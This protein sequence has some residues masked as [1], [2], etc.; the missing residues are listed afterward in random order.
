MVKIA[1]KSAVWRTM[2]LPN[3]RNYMIGNLFSQFGMWVQRIAVAWL[4]W[5]LTQSPTWLGIIAM[6]D[7]FPNVIMAPLAGA[8]AD[9]MDRLKAIRVYVSV[10]AIISA[11]IAWLTIG[12]QITV[13]TLLILVLANGIVM[14]FNYPVRLSLIQSLVGR[15]ALTS[16]VSVNAIFF[17]V[18]RI[19]GPAMAGPAI[20]VWG[21]GP[22]LI[23]TVIADIIFV[24]VLYKVHLLDA[25]TKTKPKPAR[26]LPAEIK[27][28]FRYAAKHPGIGPLLIILVTMAIFGRSF[29]ELLP[30]FADNIFGRG[31]DGFA[32]FTVMM[33]LGSFI[34][35]I[36]LAKREG[37]TGLTNILINNTLLL[38]V[39]AI[40]FAA[41]NIFWVGLGFMII[42]GYAI[43]AIGVTEQTLIQMAVDDSMR[44]RML[45]FYTLI[46]RGCPSIGALLMGSL[47]SI[48]GLQLPIIFGAV[49]C[50]GVWAWSRRKRDLL[51]NSL[52]G[53]LQKI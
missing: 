7:F 23:F 19:G 12:G 18:A 38:S 51:V 44:G 26:H 35:S 21:V 34:G 30:G 47:S 11:I 28:G 17:N 5:E 24:A 46:A 39:S 22:V 36:V 29:I 14:S 33:G 50:I 15:D 53:E 25:G 13:E 48:F 40:G 1:G 3:Y 8:L 37:V 32:L 2:H 6:A 42:V 49:I 41:T 45:S 31:V 10:S 9:R 52:E 4:T 16:A 20:A 27:E 43:V